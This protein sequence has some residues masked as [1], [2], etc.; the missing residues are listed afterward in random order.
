M[1]T[2][3]GAPATEIE[4]PDHEALPLDCAER[5]AIRS[6]INS[7]VWAGERIGVRT[8]IGS[9]IWAR[10]TLDETGSEDLAEQILAF[11][12]THLPASRNR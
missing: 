11:V 7:M 10:T 4:S 9:M 6:R 3:T 12:E 5:A 1:S 8:R 2:A